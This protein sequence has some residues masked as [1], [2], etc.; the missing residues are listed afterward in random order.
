MHGTISLNELECKIIETRSFQR[1]RNVKQLSLAY[2]VYPGADYSRFSHSV[3]ACHVAAKILDVLEG[4]DELKVLNEIDR[5]KRKQLLRVAFLLH[6]IGHYPFSHV[7][8]RAL[9]DHYFSKVLTAPREDH[10]GNDFTSIGQRHKPLRH[11]Q[12]GERIIEYDEAQKKFIA[13]QKEYEHR[14][15]ILV[16]DK[17]KL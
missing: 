17:N 10:I 7:T 11:E 15:G 16:S 8:E 2:L 13:T 1:L 14:I 5:K 12:V 6:D 9:E 4:Q 3:G